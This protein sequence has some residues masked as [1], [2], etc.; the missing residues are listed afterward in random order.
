MKEKIIDLKYGKLHLI[1]TKK[2][3]SINIKVLL[4][5]IIKKEDITKRNLLTDYLVLSTNKYPTRKKLALKIQDLYSLYINSFNTRIGNYLITRFS[6]SMLNPKYTEK[7]MLEESLDLFHEIIFNPNVKNH[8]FNSS[9]FKTLKNDLEKEI[10]T[11]KENP[12][13]YATT[14]MLEL[15]GHEA[16]SYRGIGYLEDLNSINEKNLYQY[17]QD[18]LYKSDVDIYVIGDFNEKEMTSLIKEKL[19]FK[20]IK[21]PKNE[22]TIYHDKIAKKINKIVESEQLNQSKLSIGCTLKDLTEFERKYVINLYNMILGGGFNS[23]F[24]QEIREKKSMA[25]YIHSVVNKADNLLIIQSGISKQNFDEVLK[26]IRKIMKEMCKESAT[27]EEL[28]NSK[29]EYLSILDET[30]DNMDSIIENNIAKNLLNL[31]E[32][33]V[34]REEIKKVTLDDIKNVAKKV[35]IDTVYLLKGDNDEEGRI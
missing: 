2:F 31:D 6:L 32:M 3:R 26:L 22:I 10:I 19:D 15:L 25:Y 9:I 13:A 5:D 17:Y 24:M 12:K 11:V 4:K 7:T 14:R 35:H 27:E 1:K 28:E 8:E 21:K 34:R 30:N 18:F 20:T 29:I 33:D 16:Y 23:K